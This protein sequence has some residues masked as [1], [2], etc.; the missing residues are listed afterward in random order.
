MKISW[1]QPLNAFFLICSLLFFQNCSPPGATSQNPDRNF[2]QAVSNNYFKT[3]QKFIVEVYYEPGAE[4]F[5]GNTLSGMPYWNILE[6]N[7]NAIFQ[8]RSQIPVVVV[9]KQLNEMTALSAQNKAS[10]TSSEILALY[11]QNH[12]SSTTASEAHFYLYFLKGVYNTGS[13]PNPNVLGLSLGG[14]PVIAIFKDVIN[15]S[16]NNAVVKKY[17]E[18]STLVH[19]MGH[20]LGFVNNGVP[21]AVNHQDTEHGAHTTN[22]DCV[23]YW[24]NEGAGDLTNFVQKYITSGSTLMWGPEVLKDAENFSE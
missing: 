15:G 12:Q 16:S 20:A 13:G 19:E 9:P 3:T 5:A 18:Q 4:P 2:P 8:Y 1:N 6:D 14:T 10:W 24:M 22:S 21:M 7:L 23:M 17:V 11:G